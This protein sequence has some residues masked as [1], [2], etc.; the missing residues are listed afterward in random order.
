M[1]AFC[2]REKLVR[3]QTQKIRRGSDKT[4]SNQAGTK[5]PAPSNFKILGT[6]GLIDPART[7]SEA[8]SVERSMLS[9]CNVP[10]TTP[11]NFDFVPCLFPRTLTK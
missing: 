1:G 7:S 2:L 9:E 11:G 5:N 10:H 4:I 3:N 6:G 8:Q